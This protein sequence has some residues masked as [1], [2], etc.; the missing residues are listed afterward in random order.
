MDSYNEILESNKNEKSV[1]LCSEMA[2]SPKYNVK[3]ERHKRIQSVGFHLCKVQKQ[4]KQICVISTESWLPGGV[5]IAKEQ[6]GTVLGTG[7]F[8]FLDLGSG[9]TVCLF[10][11]NS[12]NTYMY[13]PVYFNV[14][15]SFYFQTIV[16]L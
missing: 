7:N 8:L 1:T 12:S 10:C 16:L 3:R 2:Q 5:V 14:R 15:K 9:Y 4:V 6:G 11:E 13:F